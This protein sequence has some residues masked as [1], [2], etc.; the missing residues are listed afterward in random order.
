MRTKLKKKIIHNILQ[1]KDKIKKK[2]NKK[3]NNQKNKNRIEKNN[4]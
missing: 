2:S 4:I 3:I 1:L